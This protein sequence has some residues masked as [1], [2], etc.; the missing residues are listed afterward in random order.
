MNTRTHSLPTPLPGELLFG[1]AARTH[2]ISG[3]ATS[4]DTSNA[5]FGSSHAGLQHDFPASLGVLHARTGAAFQSVREII[6]D[7]TLLPYFLPLRDAAKQQNF[8][9]MLEGEPRQGLKFQ[10]GLLTSRFGASHPLKACK[11]CMA[12]DEAKL[13]ISWWRTSHQ[14][15]SVFV[16]LDHQEP[17]L[18]DQRKI[19]RSP[20]AYVLP[21]LGTV[22]RAAVTGRISSNKLE[23][24]LRLAEL[25]LRWSP[26]S[27][28]TGCSQADLISA[29]RCQAIS[30]GLGSTNQRL[31]LREFSADYAAH[32]SSVRTIPGLDGLPKSKEEAE[33][34]LAR[35]LGNPRTGTH[36]I[37]Y[38]S[39][40]DFLFSS[41]DH[42]IDAVDRRPACANTD[43]QPTQDLAP[44]CGSRV[45]LIELVSK[46]GKSV[47]YAARAVGIDLPTAQ[48]ICET[49]GI[50]VKRRPSKLSARRRQVLVQELRDGAPK[51]LIAKRF[52]ISRA[53]VERVIRSTPNLSASWRRARFLKER[54]ERRARWKAALTTCGPRAKKSAR[55]LDAATYAWL[56]RNDRSWL[57]NSTRAKSISSKSNNSNLDWA[58]RDAEL[59]A[60]IAT[61]AEKLRATGTPAPFRLWELL[62]EVPG[63]RS[64]MKHLERLPL[65]TSLLDQLCRQQGRRR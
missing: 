18:L 26:K 19:N 25:S 21:E 42:F 41:W 12:S 49:D 51:D 34:Q 9:R 13:G 29:L 39:L 10:L 7:R 65:T 55:G 35:I 15:P 14:L 3:Y 1:W 24:L 59:S 8:M 54:K 45:K 20:Y 33:S 43:E 63:L 22:W 50:E 62:I 23:H 28:P 38:L 52:A 60:A 30:A 46:G 31:R 58:G 56:Y 11:N 5:L 64:K 6:E 48:S 4:Q 16:C 44:T 40:I 17:L 27:L 36:P 57:L 2:R 47:T 53:S 37:R 32:V 61:A